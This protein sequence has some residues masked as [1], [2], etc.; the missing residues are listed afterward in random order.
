MKKTFKKITPNP[1]W[2]CG[3]VPKIYEIQAGRFEIYC[4]CDNQCYLCISDR[5]IAIETWNRTFGVIT[6]QFTQ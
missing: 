4:S 5:G 1:H 3:K 6:K 2:Y